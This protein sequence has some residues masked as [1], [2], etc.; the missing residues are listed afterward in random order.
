LLADDFLSEFC[1]I[2]FI[3]PEHW[4]RHFQAV[5]TP[6]AKDEPL[7]TMNGEICMLDQTPILVLGAGE[8]GMAILRSL[9]KRASQR[10]NTSLTVLLRPSTIA[11]HDPAKQ[12]DIAELRSLGV[13]ILAGD[14]VEA[15]TAELASLFKDFHTVIGCTGFVTGRRSLLKQAQAALDAGVRR[16]LPWQFGVDYDIIGRGSAQDLFDEQLDVRDLLRSQDRMEWIIVSTGMF[17][18]FLFEPSFGVVDLAKNTLHA[19]GSWDTAVTV[20][21][22]EDIGE[23][24]AE[25]LFT[26]PRIANRVVYTAGDTLTYRQL[27]DIIDTVLNRQVQRVEWPVPLLKDELAQDPDNPLKKYR[28][29]F[30]EGPGVSWDINQTFNAQHNI[31]VKTVEQWV[32]ENLLNHRR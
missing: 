19:L 6:G 20:T 12:R 1:L 30:A 14:L 2:R 17:T 27:A 26:E 24:T 21:T 13:N 3:V 22:P 16:F 31:K 32:R 5:I 4:E 10:S 9:S 25:I 23:L 15:S 28:V 29:V 18:S 7:S 11:S 8:L